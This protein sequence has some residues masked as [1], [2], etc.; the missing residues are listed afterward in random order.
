MINKKHIIIT[1]VITF[2]VTAL[3]MFF[4]LFGGLLMLLPQFTD[5]GAQKMQRI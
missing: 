1:A 3:I 2:I 5:G 4:T